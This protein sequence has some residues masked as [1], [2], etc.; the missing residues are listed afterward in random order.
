[1]TACFAGVAQPGFVAMRTNVSS[2]HIWA[3]SKGAGI[4]WA[5]TYVHAMAVADRS[6]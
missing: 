2:A 5:P 1:M 4:G 6:D 3:I